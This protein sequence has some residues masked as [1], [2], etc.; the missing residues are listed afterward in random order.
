MNAAINAVLAEAAHALRQGALD[1]AE[2]A[3]APLTDAAGAQADAL[4]L[5]A[6]VRRKQNRPEDAEVFARRAVAADPARGEFGSLLGAL[7]HARRA[8]PEAIAAYR[9]AIAREPRLESARLNLVLCLLASGNAEEAEREARAL[10][11]ERPSANAFGL[12]SDAQRDLGRLEEALA[13]ADA[14]VRLAPNDAATLRRRA[15]ARDQTGRVGEALE[16]YEALGKIGFDAPESIINYARALVLANRAAE[17]EAVLAQALPRWAGDDR[18]YATLARLKWMRGAGADFAAEMEAAVRA[19]PDDVKLRLACAELLH[20]AEQSAKAETLLRE[21][22]AAAPDA[23]PLL[24]SLGVVLDEAGCTEE[25][26]VPLQRALALAPE[27]DAFRANLVTALLRANHPDQALAHIGVLRTRAPNDQL[28]LAR[29]ALALRMLGDARYRMLYDYARFVRA[30]DLA[31]P[32][33]YADIASFNAAFAETLRALHDSNAHPLDQSLRHG[34]QTRGN[35]LDRPEPAIKEFL[36]ALEAPIRV[37]IDALSPDDPMGRR[38]AAGHKL[39]GCWSVRLKRGGFHA[40]HVH[41]DGWIS[42]AY[43]VSLPPEVETDPARGGWL[44]FGEPNLPMP[45][46]T[47][48]H[49]VA[50]RAGRLVLFP[51]YMWHGTTPFTQGEERLTAAFDVAPT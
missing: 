8:F 32:P 11:A 30:Y 3:L 28:L 24:S 6:Q 35:L 43:Y 2:R 38:R 10:T 34:S 51:A 29:E 25:A 12:L 45:G 9:E 20:R 27:A 23:P 37:Y 1:R 16:D 7:L 44:A 41:P 14:G 33:G 46:C 39:V 49:F 31:P 40:N 18:L 26:L 42:S 22:L 13:S 48:E 36:A 5:M 15:L 21:G 19:R 50:P 4:Y 17:A 47:P